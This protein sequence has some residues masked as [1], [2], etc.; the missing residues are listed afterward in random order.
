MMHSEIG[1]KKPSTK[2]ADI[3]KQSQWLPLRQPPK[4]VEEEILE[5]SSRN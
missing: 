2:V 1:N 3:E 4:S 5:K